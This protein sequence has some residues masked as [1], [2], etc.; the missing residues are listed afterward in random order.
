MRQ[1]TGGCHEPRLRELPRPGP[2]M[3]H[4]QYEGAPLPPRIRRR[5][6]DEYRHAAQRYSRRYERAQRVRELAYVHRQRNIA[7]QVRRKHEAG[8]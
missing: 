6:D 5:I 1:A 2:A 3:S 7:A 4:Y 8:E